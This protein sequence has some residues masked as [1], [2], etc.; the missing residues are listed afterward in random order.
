[1]P[2]ALPV[3]AP[4]VSVGTPAGQE[5]APSVNAPPLIVPDGVN[6]CVWVASAEPVN[7][8]CVKVPVAIVG[9]PAGHEIVGCVKVPDAM[10]GTP[11]GHAIVPP[12]APVIVVE[13]AAPDGDVT[14]PPPV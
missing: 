2:K 4:A 8:G 9:T 12:G 14:T 5:I 3:N 13:L 7:V 10:V 6:E 1:M 11:A